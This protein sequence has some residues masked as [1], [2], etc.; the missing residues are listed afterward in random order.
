MPE[1]D[2][3]VI[4]A[5]RQIVAFSCHTALESAAYQEGASPE[6]RCLSGAH[7]P[8]PQLTRS[9]G[10]RMQCGLESLL[11]LRSSR[12][13]D[14]KRFLSKLR[15]SKIPILAY[16]ELRN[17]RLE[18]RAELCSVLAEYRRCASQSLFRN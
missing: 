4:R 8:H 1:A 14:A 2:P 16:V 18:G 11:P 15:T 6:R 9:E 10:C 12:G 5:R 7:E 17:L 13:M 3:P